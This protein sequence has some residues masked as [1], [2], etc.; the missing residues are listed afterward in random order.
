MD[1]YMVYNNFM[2]KPE[3][4]DLGKLFTGRLFQIPEYQR[5]YSWGKK[6]RT[7]LFYDIETSYKNKAKHFMATIVGLKRDTTTIA[8]KEHSSVDIVDGQQRITTLIILYKAIGKVLNKT[9]EEK[10]AKQE[11]E[12]TLV[13]PN[14]TLLLLQTNHD[15]SN[16]FANYLRKGIRRPAN[17]AK[18]SA[19]LNLLEALDDCEKKVEVW[20]DEKVNLMKLAQHI[21]NKLMFLYHEIDEESLVYSVFEV[22]NSRGLEVPWFDR[23]KST[24]LGM[25]FECGRNVGMLRE[26]HASWARIFQVIGTLP[27]SAEILSF[28][29]TLMENGSRVLP[30][31]DSV[32]FLRK[33]SEGSHSKIIATVSWLEEVAKSVV[34]IHTNTR[35]VSLNKIKQARL[36]AVAIDLHDDFSE[37]EKSDLYS[38]C[39]KVAFCIYGISKK[40]SRTAVGDYVRLASKIYRKELSKE[41]IESR[42]LLIIKNVVPSFKQVFQ[43]LPETDC[44]N[45]WHNELR[46]LLSKYEEDLSLGAGLDIKNNE[47]WSRIWESS[48]AK[49]IEHIQPQISGSEYIHYLGNLFLL[50]PGINAKLGKKPPVD[51]AAEYEATGFRMS[52]DIVKAL[53]KWDENAVRE[54]GEKIAKWAEEKWGSLIKSPTPA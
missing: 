54:R 37:K 23:L 11:I 20:K 14:S 5:S 44:Y 27:V 18:T 9:N 41:Q 4:L 38:Y 12:N 26:V 48:P 7:E 49:T 15:T 1:L 45:K 32:N 21:T 52:K 13:K 22:L 40:D 31:A 42:L 39:S 25:F 35:E 2:L 36:V 28:A 34:K 51:K 43:R 10:Q 46:Y 19:D 47:Q 50:P 6:Q 16:Y 33:K 17:Q 8:L 30:E 3:H 29:A 53:S 24:L